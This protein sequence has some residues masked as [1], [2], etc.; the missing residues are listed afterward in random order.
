MDRRLHAERAYHSIQVRTASG[1]RLI[2]MLY[3]GGIRAA[4][5]A[6][7]RML[8]GNAREAYK[9]RGKLLCILSG[10][11]SSLAVESGHKEVD[12]FLFLYSHMSKLARKSEI[13]DQDASGLDEILHILG[14]LRDC[15]SKMLLNN[16]IG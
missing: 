5:L 11:M 4:S 16:G 12:S 3:E 2:L 6:R 15:W 9:H 7:K 14:E 1:P 10:L 13:E 8:E